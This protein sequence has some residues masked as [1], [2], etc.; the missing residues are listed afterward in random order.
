MYYGGYPKTVAVTDDFK[1]FIDTNF[2]TLYRNNKTMLEAIRK[3]RQFKREDVRARAFEKIANSFF[4]EYA[5]YNCL[6]TSLSTYE[7]INSKKDKTKIK[8]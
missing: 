4:R 2:Y 1:K 7:K 6:L 5:N 8:E 3:F